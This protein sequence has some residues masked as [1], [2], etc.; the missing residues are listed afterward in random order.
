MFFTVSC[1]SM[2]S[3]F[4]CNLFWFGY[5]F[6]FFLCASLFDLISGL[7]GE[8]CKII[9]SKHKKTQMIHIMCKK[10]LNIIINNLTM[11]SVAVIFTEAIS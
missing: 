9:S 2:G 10:E 3:V 6:A 1:R 4:G 11:C 7:K 5:G 8:M